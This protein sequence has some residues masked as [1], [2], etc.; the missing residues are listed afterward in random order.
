MPEDLT[1]QTD[2]QVLETF[3][4]LCTS[5]GRIERWIEPAVPDTTAGA[6]QQLLGPQAQAKM[7][8]LLYDARKG[9]TSTVLE[10][11]S[12]HSA[13]LYGAPA[14]EQ[15]LIVSANL[16]SV[17]REAAGRLVQK[18]PE[19]AGAAAA[20]V[21]AATPDRATLELWDEVS[22]LNNDL[23]TLHRHVAKQNAELRWLNERKNQLLGMAAHDL[24]NPIGAIIMLADFIREGEPI[25]DDQQVLL[26]EIRSSSSS[27]LRLIDDI[28]DLSS[29]ESGVIRLDLEELEPRLVLGRVVELLTPVARQKEIELDIQCDDGLQPIRADPGKLSQIIQNLISNALKFSHRRSVVRISVRQDA[30]NLLISVADEGVGIEQGDLEK[31]FQP[32]VRARSVA[33]ENEKSTGLGLAIVKRLVE[34]HGGTIQVESQ[35]GSGSTFTVVLPQT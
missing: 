3:I 5:S 30:D 19:I 32:F 20:I 4:L 35:P 18:E 29:I 25:S 17:I 8:Q 31:L 21:E 24:R 27:M 1:E 14:G 16:P 12:G 28:L 22:K 11:E 6:L 10:L 7:L 33:T 23:A 2:D 13:H 34:A 9:A 26:G 15:I